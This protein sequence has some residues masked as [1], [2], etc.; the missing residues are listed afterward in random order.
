MKK[1]ILILLCST[2]LLLGLTRAAAE[3]DELSTYNI[4]TYCVTKKMLATMLVDYQ[5]LPSIA[6]S[7]VRNVMTDNVTVNPGI[8]FVNYSTKTWTLVE[9]V[10]NNKFCIVAIG[11]DITP[12]VDPKKYD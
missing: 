6:M 4:V 1:I 7:S 5:E 11:Q 2:A 8:L 10:N 9:K 3:I 12:Y